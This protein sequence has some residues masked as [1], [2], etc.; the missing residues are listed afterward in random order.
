MK[1]SKVLKQA[2]VVGI[3][4][5]TLSTT[6]LPQYSAVSANQIKAPLTKSSLTHLKLLEA[7]EKAISAPEFDVSNGWQVLD[8]NSDLNIALEDIALQGG[9]RE[10]TG[11]Q[12][13]TL[14]FA[15]IGNSNF[16]AQRVIKM[17]KGNTYE[18][19]LLY[20]LRPVGKATGSISF[21]GTVKT[22][23][24]YDQ[25]YKETV[26]ATED[27]DYT[28][29]AEFTSPKNT[30]IFMM[31]GYDSEADG[32][33][34]IEEATV[35]APVVTTPEAG[36]SVIT[37][38]ATDGNTVKAVDSKNNVLGETTVTADGTFTIDTVRE[39][40]YQEDVTLV[41]IDKDG[42]E[43]K[44]TTVTVDD[45][46]APEKPTAEDIQLMEGISRGTAELESGI[47]VK[48]ANGNV[49]GEGK[50]SKT[51]GVFEIKLDE[52][53]A[54]N[55]SILITATDAAGNESEATEVKV[56]DT[57]APEAPEVNS[58]TDQESQLSG[59][60]MKANSEVTA[61]INDQYFTATADA[62]GEFVID[63]GRTFE[64]GTMIDVTTKDT[65]GNTSPVTS[66]MV[67]SNK[68]TASPVV[69]TVGDSDKVLT[70]LAEKNAKIELSIEGATYKGTADD[71][72]KFSINMNR[73]YKIGTQGTATANGI[74]G[75]VSEPTTF[76]FVDNTAPDAPKVNLITDEDSTLSGDTEANAIVDVYMETPE[77]GKYRYQGVADSDGKYTIDLEQTFK[78]NTKVSV[79]AKDAAGNVSETTLK[80]V[81]NSKELDIAMDSVT[82]QDE[83]ITG[84]TSRPNT[85]YTFKIKN[86]VF[87]GVS[88]D[89]GEFTVYLPNRYE[90]GTAYTYSAKD[91]D[92][93]TEILSGI[94]LPRNATIKGASKDSKE[95]YGLG[96][97]E[98]E[99]KVIITNKD[100]EV[101]EYT[102]QSDAEGNYAVALDVALAV[103]DE[104]QVIQTKF[105]IQGN[106]SY[107]FIGTR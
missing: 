4:G 16:L 75:K 44:P 80:K 77:E 76:D 97:P 54:L 29:T 22:E 39:L 28:I 25:S 60:A 79:T 65:A 101:T 15:N 98:A 49:I 99:V 93:E 103:G 86:R 13:A 17:K 81:M 24:G 73:T 69:N 10:G 19:N 3:L 94:V 88:D 58:I 32:G 40:V 61:T 92:N 106:T 27:M 21:N 56:I 7:K 5:T 71:K 63:L 100:N 38:E 42:N 37:G 31:V 70:G 12:Y 62:D 59:N 66:V 51:D 67:T 102:L 90:V 91:D 107:A 14:N 26:V 30:G 43:S 48:S 55:D 105:D 35:K 18:L 6:I 82:S 104:I 64:A 34:I 46:I 96:D 33:G 36:T 50:S 74:S 78:A 53:I 68:Q 52:A 83:E 23:E 87:E 72:G 95:I 47:K 45:T 84:V 9:H 41:Q 8:Y 85:H 1:Y 20:G 57:L 89:K 2:V 11:I